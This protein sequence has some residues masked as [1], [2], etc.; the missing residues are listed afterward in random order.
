MPDAPSKRGWSRI[1]QFQDCE[2]FWAYQTL[3]VP[4]LG[5]A[6]VQPKIRPD[7]FTFGSAFHEAMKARFRGGDLNDMLSAGLEKIDYDCN[8]FDN[9][10][11][12][13]TDLM[14]SLAELIGQYVAKRG[15][16]REFVPV[17]VNGKL[18]VEIELEA[19]LPGGTP[20][21]FRIDLV[22]MY[23]GHV[24]VPEHKTTSRDLP[25]FFQQWYLDQ[26]S[27][28][29]IWALRQHGFPE[30]NK[31]LVNAVKK[32]RKN[33]KERKYE[34]EVQMFERSEDELR[35][36][37]YET[38]DL[39][40]RMDQVA[41]GSR[42][43]IRRTANCIDMFGGICPFHLLCRYGAK[44]EL[45]AQFRTQSVDEEVNGGWS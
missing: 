16:K 36:W 8:N 39:L 14:E 9:L 41:Q 32:P 37:A 20:M 5:V 13:R 29:Y 38:E 18:G 30:A 25:L 31:L 22:T 24:V 33:A 34:F 21:T 17:E 35:R 6:T 40:R 12:L 11:P 1:A 10:I 4:E 27:T 23:A 28:G 15:P 43:P 2:Q 3:G 42:R 45:V 26:K 7:Y 19:A 44:A